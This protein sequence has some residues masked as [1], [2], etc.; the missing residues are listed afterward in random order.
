MLLIWVW[1]YFHR[2]TDIFKDM[3]VTLIGS[4]NVA[5]V[6]GKLMKKKQHTIVQVY[7]RNLPAA[8]QL[9]QTLECSAAEQLTDEADLYLLAVSD[10]SLSIVSKQLEF[11]PYKMVVHT[12][13]AVSLQTLQGCSQHIGILYPLQSLRK[14]ME[15]IPEIPFYIDGNTDQMRSTLYQFALTLSPNVSYAPDSLRLKL[16]LAAV[17]SSNFM[18]HLLALTEQ[19]CNEEYVNFKSLYPLLSETVSRLQVYSPASLQTGPAMRKDKKTIQKHLS[20]LNHY[21]H[22]EQLYKC[23]TKSIQRLYK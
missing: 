2:N 4:G 8:Q 9:A 5:T 23:F 15:S 7:S 14:E 1:L 6:L 11:P 21:P 22:L 20:L 13:G 12:S 18:N 16:H 19:Y 10:D 17:M 3:K